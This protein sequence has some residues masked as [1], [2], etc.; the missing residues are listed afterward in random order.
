MSAVTV[1][2]R[3]RRSARSGGKAPTWVRIYF[4]AVSLPVIGILLVTTPTAW[5]SSDVSAGELAV[6]LLVVVAADLAPVPVWQSVTLSM[7]LPVTLAAGMLFPAPI[8]GSIA[9]A[10]SLDQREFKGEVS[11]DRAVY[12]RSQ[13]ALSVFL[14]SSA[15]HATGASVMHWPSVLFP[16]SLALAVDFFSN[17]VLVAFPLRALAHVSMRA[18]LRNIIGSP[19]V[20]QHVVSYVSVGMLAVTLATLVTRAGSWGVLVF[21]APLFIARRELL[22]ASQVEESARRIEEKNRALLATVESVAE[23]RRD[24]RLVVAGELHDEVLPPLFK[25]HLMGQVL[26]RDLDSGRLLS[27]DDDLPDLLSA[28]DAAQGAIRGMLGDLRRSPL[29]PGGLV[30]TLRRLVQQLEAE[31]SSRLHMSTSQ[32]ECSPMTQLL[33]Y[34]IAREALVNAVRHAHANSIRVRLW[35]DD[36]VIRL[37]VEDDGVGFAT[38]TREGHFGLQMMAE[39]AEAA[40]GSAIIDSEPG[41]GTR[42]AATIPVNIR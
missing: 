25:V 27:L 33:V 37:V 22:R 12:N 16:A 11:L 4:V 30:P 13:V 20:R 2:A 32:I 10:G 21:L 24:E 38:G 29:G 41:S 28:I 3:R 39:R 1:G 26:R 42:V 6:W 23:E 9:F 35:Q 19:S 17:T 8:A 40:Q 18:A 15:F 5:R 34:Q 36:A 31:G 14:A 7:S